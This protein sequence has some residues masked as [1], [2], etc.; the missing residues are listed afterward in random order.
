VLKRTM[1]VAPGAAPVHLFAARPL[2]PPFRLAPCGL[3]PAH[4]GTRRR[5]QH[6]IRAMMSWMTW[7]SLRAGAS[8]LLWA[9]SWSA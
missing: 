1:L 5:R 8:V 4:R 6:M 7:A 3:R 2:P 9:A